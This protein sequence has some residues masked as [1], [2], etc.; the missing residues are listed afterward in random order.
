MRR[1]RMR[2]RSGLCVLVLFAM[3]AAGCAAGSQTS[4]APP[5][6]EESTIPN[7]PPPSKPAGSPSSQDVIEITGVVETGVEHGCTMLRTAGEL[8][9]LTGSTDPLIR[10]GARLTVR[11]RPRPDLLTTCQQGVPFQ[12]I[13]VLPG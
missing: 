7:F 9:Q 5:S 3:V 10:P 11:G 4:G 12:V 8:Y 2:E 13:E 1:L 6:G